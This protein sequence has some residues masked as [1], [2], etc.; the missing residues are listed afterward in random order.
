MI[1]ATNEISSFFHCNKCMT[2]LPKGMS[3]RE[4][5]E[6]EVGFTELGFQVWCKRHEINVIHMDFEGQKHHANTSAKSTT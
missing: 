3:P 1:P 6:L 4:W 2:E 5:A